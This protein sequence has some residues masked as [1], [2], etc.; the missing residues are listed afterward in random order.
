MFYLTFFRIGDI[1]LGGSVMILIYVAVA[2]FITLRRPLL[3]M[4][5][6]E[7]MLKYLKQVNHLEEKIHI[8]MSTAIVFTHRNLSN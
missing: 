7:E 3:S 5:S 8:C 6:R 1:L 4:K 2:L